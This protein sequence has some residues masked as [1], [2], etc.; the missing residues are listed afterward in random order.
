MHDE[1]LD[2]EMKEKLIHELR[3]EIKQ[4]D[5]AIEKAAKKLAYIHSQID[6]YDDRPDLHDE[7]YWLEYL[8]DE[9]W[10]DPD[11]D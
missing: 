1:D 6:L 5:D 3:V 4:R 2:R 8:R 7:D 11:I 9:N 10:S